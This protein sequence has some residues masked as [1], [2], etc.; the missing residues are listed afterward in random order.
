VLRV[1]GAV[2]LVLWGCDRASQATLSEI[3]PPERPSEPGAWKDHY[4]AMA[5]FGDGFVVWES[6]RDRKWRIWLRRLDGSP[7]KQISPDEP[8]RD[9]VAAHVSPDGRHL[10]YLSLPAPHKSFDPLPP[11]EH[12]ALHL[13]TLGPDLERVDDRVL[14]PSARTYYQSRAAVWV[15]PRRLVYIAG[16]GTTHE[17]DLATGRGRVLIPTP[18]GGHGMLVNATYTHATTGR[19]SFSPYHERD[20]TVSLAKVIPGCQPYFTRDGRFGYWQ[21][22]PGG[23]IRKLDLLTRAATDVLEWNSPFLP[24]GLRYVYYP[25]VSPDQRLFAFAASKGRH[26]HFEVDFEIFVA[27]L[28]PEKLEVN[29][30]AVRYSENPTQD[31]FPDVFL[32]GMELGHPRGEAPLHVTFTPE[33]DLPGTAGAPWTFDYG[34]GSPPSARP[35]HVY[36]T[37]GKYRVSARRGN[38]VLGGEVRVEPGAPPRPLRAEVRPGAREIAVVFDE[39]VDVSKAEAKLA[40][41]AAVEGIALGERGHELIATLA[42]PLAKSDAILVEGVS[43]RAATPHPMAPA[44]LD[45]A[46]AEWPGPADGL[47]FLYETEGAPNLA[48]D[49]DTGRERS[50]G[51]APRGRARFDANGALWTAGGWFEVEDLPAGLTGAF[52]RANALTLE[53]TVWPDERPSAD[54]SFLL[55]LGPDAEHQNLA[56]VQSGLHLL[57]RL[58]TSAAKGKKNPRVEFGR[59][60][61]GKPNHLLVTYAPGRLTAYQDGNP[62]LDADSIEGDLST[63]HDVSRLSLGAAQDGSSGFAGRIEGV[64]LYARALGREEAVAHGNAYLHEVARREPV[65]RFVVKARLGALSELPTPEQIAPYREGLVLGEYEVVKLKQGEIG[66]DR[67]RV[68]HW[69]IL[70]GAPQPLRAAKSGDVVRLALEPWESYPRLESAYLS[71]TLAPDGDAPLFLDVTD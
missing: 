6:L 21:A 54:A 68:A 51:L 52:R 39:R 23:P 43:D 28:D 26:G 10:V 12:A 29:G 20:R 24:E 70:D 48:R 33:L 55:A 64:A 37:P 32:A 18:R 27:P 47:V 67:V 60:E 2:V 9:H 38:S 11:G 41:G 19:P 15:S 44:R 22:D 50:F 56:L 46:V 45:V 25:M 4:R 61:P 59:L 13:L 69:A 42:A 14:V 16:D 34:D 30:T 17:L 7:E 1:L 57:L 35:T 71:D 62:V 66:A 36:A 31:R 63:W 53:L 40:S 49:L 3:P 58:R 8:G 5:A 65:P